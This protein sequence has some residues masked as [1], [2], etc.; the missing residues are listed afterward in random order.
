MSHPLHEIGVL[1]LRDSSCLFLFP[2]ACQEEYFLKM[3][4]LDLRLNTFHIF[5]IFTPPPPPFEL[6]PTSLCINYSTALG[7]GIAQ[8]QFNPGVTAT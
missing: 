6:L 1:I 4:R 5:S 2:F 8:I 3:V 7:T